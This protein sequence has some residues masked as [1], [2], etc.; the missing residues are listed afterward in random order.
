MGV[1]KN[2]AVDEETHRRLRMLAAMLGVTMASILK[3]LV[4]KKWD[5]KGFIG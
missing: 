4:S 3:D 1:N 2:I 5:E